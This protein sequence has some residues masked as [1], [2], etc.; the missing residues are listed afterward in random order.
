M[1]RIFQIG[2]AVGCIVWNM[3]GLYLVSVG[4]RPIGPTASAVAAGLC[5]IFAVLFWWFLKKNL[6]WPYIILCAVATLM[7]GIAVYGAF[8][9][10]LSLWPSEGWRWA[11]I[12]LN[13]MG[14]IACVAGILKA[15]NSKRVK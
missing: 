12:L 14:M 9:K 7:A 5:A 3:Y 10:D 4:Q 1:L 2:W 15:L 6:K 11:G 13:G 8:T